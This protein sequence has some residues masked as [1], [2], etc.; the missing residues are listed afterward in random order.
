MSAAAER[1]QKLAKECVQ[2]VECH[3]RS[4]NE[5][6]LRMLA[7]GELAKWLY[8]Q[9]SA[10]NPDRLRATFDEAVFAIDVAFA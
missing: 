7:L 3:R 6:T 9:D 4:L 1:G 8:V 2:A 5:S 10:A